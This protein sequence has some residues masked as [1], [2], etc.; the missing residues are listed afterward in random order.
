[1]TGKALGLPVYALF[2]ARPRAHPPLWSHCS[3]YRLAWPDAM[4][5]RAAH[6]R[7][8]RRCPPEVVAKGYAALKTNVFLLEDRPRL[9][10]P[11][12]ARG[13]FFPELNAERNVLAAIRDQLA[14]FR[15]GRVP[16]STFWSI[17]T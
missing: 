2:G 13:D 8:H 10:A 5:I 1:M 16:R 14:A 12:F 7:R 6:A 3:T 11:G 17:S 15:E 4:Q 9:H